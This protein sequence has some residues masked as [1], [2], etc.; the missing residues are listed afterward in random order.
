MPPKAAGNVR[1]WNLGLKTE[2]ALFWH[3]IDGEKT[4]SLFCPRRSVRFCL[5]DQG[6]APDPGIE[7]RVDHK[8]LHHYL[9]YQYVPSP[10][11]IFQGI[12]SFPR[13]I[14]FSM[15]AREDKDRA[16]LETSLQFESRDSRGRKIL[17]GFG[18]KRTR[19]NR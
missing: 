11:S 18:K 8:A 15:I 17:R 10:E 1:F 3:E 9:T 5:G 14:I 4:V 19:V 2:A 12:K 16:L 13:P 7:R 6:T